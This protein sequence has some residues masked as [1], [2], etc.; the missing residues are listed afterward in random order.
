MGAEGVGFYS[1]RA[2]LWDGSTLSFVSSG[3][4]TF[5]EPRHLM[6]SAV[7]EI[8]LGEVGSYMVL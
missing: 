3:E 8:T 5:S 6:G 4:H 1:D 7:I 2:D